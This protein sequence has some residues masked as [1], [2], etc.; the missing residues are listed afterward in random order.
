MP[1][2]AMKIRPFQG[3]RPKPELASEVASPPYDV[4]NT[5]EARELSQGN[6]KSF[7]HVVRAEIDL[8][9]GTDLYADAVYEKARENLD[10]LRESGALVRETAPSLYVYQQ[11]TNGH[12]QKGLVSVCHV[13]DYRNDLIKKHETTQPRKVDDRTQLSA[14]LNA[15]PGPVFLMYRDVPG[16]RLP[17]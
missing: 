3:L 17:G 15:H 9:E 13:D 10:W 11:E 4:V 1:S 16:D 6:P 2:V 14:T 8:P 7:L 12:W 5:E